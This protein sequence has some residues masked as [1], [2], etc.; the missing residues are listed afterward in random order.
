MD[1]KK[2]KDKLE[3]MKKKTDDWRNNQ[4]LELIASGAVRDHW[5]VLQDLPQKFKNFR[6]DKE[7]EIDPGKAFLGHNKRRRKR[8]I[9][10]HPENIV[11]P[12]K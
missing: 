4:N 9:T 10:E 3:E 7:K 11:G 8:D 5:Q 2:T 1:R 12:R 6:R